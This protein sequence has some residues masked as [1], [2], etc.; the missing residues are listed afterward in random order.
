M[1]ELNVYKQTGKM[2]VFTILSIL[3]CKLTKGY[4]VPFFVLLGV[5]CAFSNKLGWALVYFV[6]MPYFVILNPAIFPKGS[7]VVGLSLRLGPLLIGF[8]LAM[9]GMSRSGRHRLPFIG[10]I[11]FLMAALISSTSGWAPKVSFL[12]LINFVTFLFGIWYGTQNLQ[13]RPKDVFLLRSFFLAIS[14]LLVFGSIAV[15]PFPGIAFATSLSAALKEGGTELAEDVFKVMELEGMQTLFCGITNQSQALAPLLC[16]VLAL[17]SCDMLFVERRFCWPHLALLAFTLP[18]LY[19]TRSRVALITGMFVIGIVF[20]YTSRVIKLPHNVRRH[21]GNGMVVCLVMLIVIAVISQLRSGAMS[22][23]AR[24]TSDSKSDKRSLI[25]ALTSSRMP[26]IEMSLN[27]FKRNPFLG[28][29]FQVAEYTKYKTKGKS[30]IISASIEKGV[31]PVMVL[32]EGGILGV[33][34]FLIF[35]VS[36]YWICTK[37][38]YFVTITTFSVLLV[39]NM[40]EATFFSPGGIGGILWMMTCVGGFA[41]DTT[42][43]FRQQLQRQWAAMALEQIAPSDGRRYGR[44]G[45]NLQVRPR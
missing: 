7:S 19:L 10:I 36:F 27:D 3:L 31:L 2:L 11:P 41:I 42:L 18:L 37:R 28:M 6:L 26:L 1:N 32:G 25:E 45:L 38:K 35:L 13:H 9:R 44:G 16:S 23:W 21:I 17:V 33:V 34:C 20:F 22:E 5:W 30:F 14:A 39:T 43:L 8:C 24:K 15:M 12:K 4:F 29:G 40:G